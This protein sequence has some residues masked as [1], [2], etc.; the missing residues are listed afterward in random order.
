MPLAERVNLYSAL[1]LGQPNPATSFIGR[2]NS[3]LR[4]ALLFLYGLYR[5]YYT[6]LV[7]NNACSGFLLSVV[8]SKPGT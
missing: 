4:L 5:L 7:A 2:C 8:V 3:F 1:A 6:W